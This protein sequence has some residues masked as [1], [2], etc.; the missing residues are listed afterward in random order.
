MVANHI[1][2]FMFDLKLD[3]SVFVI[4][5][6]YLVHVDFHPLHNTQNLDER[7]KRNTASRGYDKAQDVS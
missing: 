5:R 4:S 1:P 2:M 7:S 3:S 6:C